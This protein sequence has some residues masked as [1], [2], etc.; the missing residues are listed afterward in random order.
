MHPWASML[1]AAADHADGDILA[2][3]IPL[4]KVRGNG[5][6]AV[7]ADLKVRANAKRRRQR[8][9]A[10]APAPT[11]RRPRAKAAPVQVLP[12]M[13]DAVLSLLALRQSPYVQTDDSA[14]APPSENPTQQ[15]RFLSP[16]ASQI[17]QANHSMSFILNG[18]ASL[19]DKGGVV[20]LPKLA[21]QHSGRTNGIRT[22]ERTRRIL[23]D[24]MDTLHQLRYESHPSTSA[25]LHPNDDMVDDDDTGDSDDSYDDDGAASASSLDPQN[26]STGLVDASG[27]FQRLL[28]PTMAQQ[29]Q[30]Q[31]SARK[32]FSTSWAQ[33]KHNFELLQVTARLE[34]ARQDYLGHIHAA[35]EE[36]MR[37]QLHYQH[38]H[39]HMAPPTDAQTLAQ[40]RLRAREVSMMYLFQTECKS[41]YEIGAFSFNHTTTSNV[42][43]DSFTDIRALLAALD[44]A[45]TSRKCWIIGIEQDNGE[46][47]AIDDMLTFH[48]GFHVLFRDDERGL[49]A[50]LRPELHWLIPHVMSQKGLVSVQA[51]LQCRYH[52]FDVESMHVHVDVAGL[53]HN[54]N[55]QVN[56]ADPVDRTPSRRLPPLP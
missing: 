38:L 20:R 52:T 11:A 39:P 53:V 47:G 6:L 34:D 50:L 2:S 17:K 35:L 46:H 56:P 42:F 27:V 3:Q 48:V 43:H 15:Q 32:P 19:E 31:Q 33:R 37:M 28:P 22:D 13:D 51:A 29:D 25:H 36:D 14:I 55:I 8:V 24:Q 7:P 10:T 40:R 49:E 9:D 41:A 54:L 1:K 4:N 30:L 45:L 5:Q 23:Q 21:S 26:R 18:G 16:L 44:G 12:N